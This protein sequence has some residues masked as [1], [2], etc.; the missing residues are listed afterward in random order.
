MRDC[1]FFSRYSHILASRQPFSALFT[2]TCVCFRGTSSTK[3]VLY[4]DVPS[5]HSKSCPLPDFSITRVY[6]IPSGVEN[7]SSDSLTIPPIR[8][9][10]SL[11]QVITIP[12]IWHKLRTVTVKRYNYWICRVLT[13]QVVKLI[14]LMYIKLTH[15]KTDFLCPAVIYDA[16]CRP[17]TISQKLCIYRNRQNPLYIQNNVRYTPHQF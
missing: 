12:A 13:T 10:S 15:L 3:A 11:P 8:R 1:T 7:A 6:G 4:K 16:F 5:A 9:R 2:G 14:G 17:Y